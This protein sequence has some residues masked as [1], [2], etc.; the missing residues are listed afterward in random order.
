MASPATSLVWADGQI[1]D[2]AG[3][4]EQLQVDLGRLLGI[5]PAVYLQGTENLADQVEVLG[6]SA[7]V[8]GY[9]E[10]DA[11]LIRKQAAVEVAAHPDDILV[12]ALLPGL[13]SHKAAPP[14]TDWFLRVEHFEVQ[15]SSGD[16]ELGF[17]PLP[18]NHLSPSAN[19]LL[20]DDLELGFV[21]RGSAD[22][23]IWLNR[24]GQVACVDQ[25]AVVILEDGAW[26]TP[27]LSDGAIETGF[28]QR[29][30]TS[31]RVIESPI[32]PQRLLDAE[33]VAVLTP[34]GQRVGVSSIAPVDPKGG[35]DV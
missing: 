4:P 1:F 3:S 9:R 5:S 2:G 13:T 24:D 34:W 31:G 6:R 26:F 21:P 15:P 27:P 33:S 35:E 14:G 28:R 10:F 16:L 23:L 22:A 20:L 18:R 17:S 11:T 32:S 8:L 7:A 19:L 29:A 30:V 12:A 25:S